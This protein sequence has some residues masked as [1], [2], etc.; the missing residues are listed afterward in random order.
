MDRL[1]VPPQLLIN[2]CLSEIFILF[3][4]LYKQ[5]FSCKQTRQTS[6]AKQTRTRGAHELTWVMRS[7]FSFKMGSLAKFQWKFLCPPLLSHQQ[8]LSW[9]VRQNQAGP[10]TSQ[11]PWWILSWRSCK[12]T[13]AVKVSQLGIARLPSWVFLEALSSPWFQTLVHT[14]IK[15]S[16]VSRRWIAKPTG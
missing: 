4:W 12:A 8:R 9:R 13:E 1:P 15:G 3:P 10:A 14:K 6:F 2:R 5:H 16:G 11:S 7:G